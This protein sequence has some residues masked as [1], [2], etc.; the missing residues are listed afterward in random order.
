MANIYCHGE[1]GTFPDT[2]FRHD[3]T[4]KLHI[5]YIHETGNPHYSTGMPLRPGADPG[6]YHLAAQLHMLALTMS[7]KELQD[8]INDIQ[9][10]DR[11]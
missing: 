2:E 9:S 6:L 8:L 11:S 4:G 1:P 10:K 7:E 5:P 3:S